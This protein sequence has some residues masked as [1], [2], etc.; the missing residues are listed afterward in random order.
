[1]G[2]FSEQHCLPMATVGE[3]AEDRITER[4]GEN[5]VRSYVHVVVTGGAVLAVHLWKTVGPQCAEG[6]PENQS[7]VVLDMAARTEPCPA[8]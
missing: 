4:H 1:M 2:L 5:K 8:G 6:R 3:Y 7:S